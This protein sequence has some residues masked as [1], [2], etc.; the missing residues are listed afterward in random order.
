VPDA[1]AGCTLIGC[2]PVSPRAIRRR[3]DNSDRPLTLVCLVTRDRCVH[4]LSRR[5]TSIAA[6]GHDSR[7]RTYRVSPQSTKPMRSRRAQTAWFFGETR[8]TDGRGRQLPP[9]VTLVERRV[10]PARARVVER[11]LTRDP[12]R[13]ASEY[14]A[15]LRVRGC[16]F[17]VR[18]RRGRF[19]GTGRLRGPRWRWTSW[20]SKTRL[21]PEGLTVHSAARLARDGVHARIRVF[22]PDGRLAVELT[23]ALPHIERP[24]FEWLQACLRAHRQ[25]V[26]AAR[27]GKRGRRR[28]R[29]PSRR[30]SVRQGM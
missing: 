18:E 12:G 11:V 19:E 16:A 30:S 6:F 2:R 3:A 10:E 26:Q 9:R 13:P 17:T 14:S 1:C 7:L 23:E 22:R 25:P 27:G 4:R 21:V 5:V 24:T 8:I 28:A 29:R 20:Y 15:V